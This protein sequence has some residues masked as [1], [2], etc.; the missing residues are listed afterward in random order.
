VEVIRH[1]CGCAGGGGDQ[2]RPLKEVDEKT[3]RLDLYHRLS[4]I[5][6][7][8]FLMTEKTIFLCW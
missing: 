2:Q 1:Q 3:F 8:A 5:D 7:R 6:S 4:V